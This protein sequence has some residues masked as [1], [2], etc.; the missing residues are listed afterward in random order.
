MNMPKVKL[1]MNAFKSHL[2]FHT[3]A[4]KEG[5]RE[6]GGDRTTTLCLEFR[7]QNLYEKFIPTCERVAAV[8]T[9][10][11]GTMSIDHIP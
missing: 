6:G 4:Q 7:F 1:M 11:K 8:S 5:E 10:K 2:C 9:P 3:R